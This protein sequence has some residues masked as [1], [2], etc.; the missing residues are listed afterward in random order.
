MITGGLLLMVGAVMPWAT[1]SSRI[2]ALT[3]TINGLGGAG[4]LTA[5]GGLVLLLVGIRVKGAPG[6]S[7]SR[8]GVIVSMLC[9]LLII[10]KVFNIATLSTEE[11]ITSSSL[12]FG[13]SFLS[14][15]GAAFGLIGSAM[16][17]PAEST[18]AP[19]TSVNPTPPTSG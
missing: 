1:I 3:R 17:T 14:P 5:S 15:L 18:P 11:G 12:R 7:F 9:G 2:W 16:K 10:W 4:I 19:I 8:L 13:L 6:K